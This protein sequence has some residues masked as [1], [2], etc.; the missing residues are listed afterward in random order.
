M[1]ISGRTYA[2]TYYYCTTPSYCYYFF[3]TIEHRAAVAGINGFVFYR[4]QDIEILLRRESIN[5][6][7]DSKDFKKL[8]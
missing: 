6:G 4:L 1:G 8:Q 2:L 5:G 3:Y 7:G